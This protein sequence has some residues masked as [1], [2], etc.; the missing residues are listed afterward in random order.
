LKRRLN[1]Q[2]LFQCILASVIVVALKG[3]LTQV[4]EFPRFKQKSKMDGFVWMA[5][6]L[7]VVIVAIDIGLLVGIILSVFC[8]FCNSLK[9]H[10]CILGNI[11]NTDIF[12]DIERFEKAIEIPSKK[13]FHYSGGINFA[14]KAS[15]RNRLCK[16][17]GVNLLKELK[18]VDKPDDKSKGKV[19]T[20]NL[21]FT[22]L[23]IDFSALSFIDPSSVKML[24]NVIRDFMKLNISVSI[25]GCTTKIY[26]ILINNEFSFVRLM[27][28]TIQDA[29][30]SQ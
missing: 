24:E 13:I 7:T 16:K 26:E 20:S 28:P 21:N 8:I 25:A 18:N 19:F 14:T 2:H 1:Q 3:M 5:T 17:L 29:I 9:A 12:L 4:T 23:I 11:P 15:F 6:F 30:H 22:H 10:I 27:Y